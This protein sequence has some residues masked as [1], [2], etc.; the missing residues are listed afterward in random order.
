MSKQISFIEGYEYEPPPP[1]AHRYKRP[2]ELYGKGPPG[3]TCK[4]CE[5]LFIRRYGNKYFKCD[6]WVISNC[7]TTDIHLKDPACGAYEEAKK[8]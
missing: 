3:K 1:T 8:E 2:I 6:K 5:H 4:T 7:T